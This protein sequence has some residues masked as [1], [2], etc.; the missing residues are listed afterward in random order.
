MNEIRLIVKMTGKESI[1]NKKKE[2]IKKKHFKKSALLKLCSLSQKS[3]FSCKKLSTFL[4]EKM[5]LKIN[6]VITR[7]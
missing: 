3:V 4:Q 7:P 6:K 2:T 1:V 5:G